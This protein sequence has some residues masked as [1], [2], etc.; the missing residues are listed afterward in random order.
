[1]MLMMLLPLLSLLLLLMM[2]MLQKMLLLPL[3]LWLTT[4]IQHPKPH[5]RPECKRKTLYGGGWDHG[6]VRVGVGGAE[7]LAASRETRKKL[8]W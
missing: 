1:M 5:L 4:I 2:L 8:M 6:V 3:L 7:G